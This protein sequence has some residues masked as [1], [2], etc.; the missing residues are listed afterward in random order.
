M[1][2]RDADKPSSVDSEKKLTKSWHSLP[3]ALNGGGTKRRSRNFT[4]YLSHR[5]CTKTVT[6][7]QLQLAFAQTNFHEHITVTVCTMVIVITDN[8][9]IVAAF[10]VSPSDIQNQWRLVG[11][12]GKT[13]YQIRLKCLTSSSRKNIQQ[14][15]GHDRAL[16]TSAQAARSY[17]FCDENAAVDWS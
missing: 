5:E 7:L 9:C 14:I 3:C 4:K 16:T 2:Y 6:G 12:L 13:L 1:R 8:Q 11:I 15:G 17:T 10:Y